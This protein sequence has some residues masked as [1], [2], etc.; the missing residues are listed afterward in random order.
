MVPERPGV[1]K[2]FQKAL[3]LVFEVYRATTLTYIWNWNIFRVLAHCDM[4]IVLALIIS[5][6]KMLKR[7]IHSE[8][9]FSLQAPLFSKKVI[10]CLWDNNCKRLPQI[11]I[12][13]GFY[14]AFRVRI[15]V[16][17]IKRFFLAKYCIKT[18]KMCLTF[19][20]YETLTLYALLYINIFF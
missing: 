1:K 15:S 19:F 4:L 12:F 13:I 7:F 2:K 18:S 14:R 8:R 20:S 11:T 10:F 16:E 3:I 17:K 6:A 9:V 5:M